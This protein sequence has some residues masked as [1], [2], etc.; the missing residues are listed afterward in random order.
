MSSFFFFLSLEYL[1]NWTKEEVAGIKKNIYSRW[2]V[3]ES[4]VLQKSD[5]IQQRPD[6]GPERRNR[7]FD[8]AS[9]EMIFMERVAVR[10]PFLRRG[11][12]EIQ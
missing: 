4:D 3:S 11:N 7:L 2:T 5:D 10:E 1:E 12:K 8:E 9:T 6:T